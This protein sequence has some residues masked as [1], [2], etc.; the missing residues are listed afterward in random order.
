MELF[1]EREVGDVQHESAK[2]P[3]QYI[4]A[5]TALS[6]FLILCKNADGQS[7]EVNEEQL[8]TDTVRRVDLK[9]R[10]LKD[11]NVA[12]LHRSHNLLL[13]NLLRQASEQSVLGKQS[14]SIQY[15]IKNDRSLIDMNRK[16]DS[17]WRKFDQRCRARDKLLN[18][19]SQRKSPIGS[20][21]YLLE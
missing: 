18:Q 8:K 21:Y 6:V 1:F 12:S 20:N 4:L 9:I 7:L 2:I 11:F 16:L 14:S 10:S 5:I 19:S 13:K 3:N 17:A 15:K